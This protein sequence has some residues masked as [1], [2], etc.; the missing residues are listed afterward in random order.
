MTFNIRY[1]EPA[2]GRQAWPHRRQA[3]VDLIAAHAPDLLALQEPTAGQWA[4]LAE[5]LSG[6]EAFGLTRDEWDGIEPHGGFF[7]I[8]RFDARDA[9]IFWLSDTPSIAHSVSWPN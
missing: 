2:D 8:D 1:D 5:K 4:D 6:Y 7:R 3:V 9:G